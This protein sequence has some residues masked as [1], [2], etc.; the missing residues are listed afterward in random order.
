MTSRS[1]ASSGALSACSRTRTLT[2]SLVTA[3]T[4]TCVCTGRD[5]STV[6]VAVVRGSTVTRKRCQVTVLSDGLTVPPSVQPA[7]AGCSMTSVRGSVSSFRAEYDAPLALFRL[8]DH[9]A[10]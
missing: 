7:R 9:H 3:F 5:S 2:W 1:A 6:N 10:A 8:L 4:D